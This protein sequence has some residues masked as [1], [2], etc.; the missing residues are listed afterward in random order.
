MRPTNSSVIHQ[1]KRQIKLRDKRETKIPSPQAKQ[2]SQLRKLFTCLSG[3]TSGSE[4]PARDQTTLS[5]EPHSIE[6]IHI[7]GTS[8]VICHLRRYYEHFTSRNQIIS[9]AR[10]IR[11]THSD[12]AT[13]PQEPHSIGPIYIPHVRNKPKHLP[14]PSSLQTLPLRQSH[15][16][17]TND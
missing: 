15:T 3:L 17:P 8:Q 10:R 11:A 1:I 9:S 12:H 14:S 7:S 16:S 4:T 2:M 13:S 6:P 5:Q